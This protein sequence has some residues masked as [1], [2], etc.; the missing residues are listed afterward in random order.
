MASLCLR[1]DKLENGHTFVLGI[2][3]PSSELVHT[4]T[5]AYCI[6]STHSGV[7]VRRRLSNKPMAA[8][9]HLIAKRYDSNGL[10]G[11]DGS[12]LRDAGARATR[13]IVLALD[14]TEAAEKLLQW[15]IVNLHR[16][17]D[18]FHV[19]HVAKILAPHEDIQHQVPGTSLS[20]H[21]RSIGQAKV[22]AERA[23]VFVRER[24]VALQIR[25]LSQAH[26]RRYPA[27][28][29]AKHAGY[30]KLAIFALL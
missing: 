12:E 18:V 28:K 5:H 10:G 6:L 19:V 13:H 1:V 20:F 2:W 29:A 4:G 7:E 30:L 22:D 25:V 9:S 16:K 24:Y 26:Q 27:S 23:K 8:P 15:A 17:G 3:Q 14:T 11:I 21:D